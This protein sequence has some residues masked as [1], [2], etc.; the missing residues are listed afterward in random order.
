[1]QPIGQFVHLTDEQME[2]R[3]RE[4]MRS[5]VDHS[6]ELGYLLADWKRR[7]REVDDFRLAGVGDILLRI[8]EG[9]LDPAVFT[10][11]WP[12][13]DTMRQLATLPL[14]DQ[15]RLATG[16]TVAVVTGK[17]GVDILQMDIE[18]IMDRGLQQ[19]VFKRGR[20]LAIASQRARIQE[21]AKD[22]SNPV[23]SAIGHL[24][25]DPE[26]GGVM[27]GKKFITLHDLE[28]AARE[29][30]RLQRNAA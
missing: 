2:S 1:M 30:R 6:L 24:V 26:R 4:A 9:Q 5:I 11:H 20:I 29:L 23:P 19:Q 27:V 18:T 14:S 25:L 22:Q 12:K 10:N 13:I 15:K 21:E 17:S 16:G 8:G 3:I 28:K 7:G